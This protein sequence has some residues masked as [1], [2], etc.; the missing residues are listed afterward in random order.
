MRCSNCGL[1]CEKTEMELSIRDIDAVEK[2]G[3]SR[4]KF[5]ITGEDGIT[6]LRNVDGWCF[7]YNQTEKQCR[8]YDVRP[9]GCFTYPVVYSAEGEVVIDELCPMRHTLS[10]Q[11]LKEK[12]KILI[13]LLNTI[14]NERSTKTENCG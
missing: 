9:I 5:T 3:Y 11:E 8:V 4:E 12:G 10:D 2:A 14:D 7:F 1:C 13:N 6:R